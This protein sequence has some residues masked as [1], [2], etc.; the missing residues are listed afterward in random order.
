MYRGSSACGKSK[1]PGKGMTGTCLGKVTDA[2]MPW[3]LSRLL[4]RYPRWRKSKQTADS[5]C[6]RISS[7]S[8]RAKF[9]ERHLAF[10]VRVAKRSIDEDRSSACEQKTRNCAKF[11][12]PHRTYGKIDIFLCGEV[13]QS[14]ELHRGVGARRN[15]ENICAM[16]FRRACFAAQGTRTWCRFETMKR[17]DSAHILLPRQF[18]DRA[19][20]RRRAQFDVDIP[21]LAQTA[22]EQIAPLPERQLICTALLRMS[23]G[24][25]ERHA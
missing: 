3:T 18:E 23:R 7:N 15:F 6:S 16:R 22:R 10:D 11:T 21:G 25:D 24:D 1:A 14:R 2:A 20:S 13:E 9:F 12:D 19:E 4:L 8:E 17:N 5:K